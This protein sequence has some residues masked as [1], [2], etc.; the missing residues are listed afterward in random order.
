MDIITSTLKMLFHHPPTLPLIVKSTPL[1][2][3]INKVR[4]RGVARIRITDAIG[5]WVGNT[6]MMR[7][8]EDVRFMV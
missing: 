7:D 1:S 4:V 2:I 6:V 5:I 3:R 8:S